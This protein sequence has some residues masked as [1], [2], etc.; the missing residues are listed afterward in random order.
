MKGNRRSIVSPSIKSPPPDPCAVEIHLGDT[1]GSGAI[2]Y[3][4][5]AGVKSC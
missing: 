4:E 5:I 3:P 2:A 1:Y